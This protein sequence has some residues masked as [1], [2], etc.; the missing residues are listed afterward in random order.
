VRSLGETDAAADVVLRAAVADDVDALLRVE[1]DANLRALAHVFPP[2]RFPYPERDVRLRWARVLDDADF[3]VTVAER[4]AAVVG[5]VAWRGDVVEHLG[6]DPE[7]QR[8]GLGTRLLA[9]AAEAIASP[10]RLWVLVD[11]EGARALYS[12]LGWSPTGREQ[13]A[14]FPPYPAEIELQAGG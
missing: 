2:E 6:V 13:P 1:R 9:H 4:D 3:S 8:R 7:D 12:R 10:A 11:N 5:F 14:E